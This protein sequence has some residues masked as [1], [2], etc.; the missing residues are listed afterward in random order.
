MLYFVVSISQVYP[1]GIASFLWAKVDPVYP[2]FL[3]LES[4]IIMGSYCVPGLSTHILGHLLRIILVSFTW[5]LL[6]PSIRSAPLFLFSG[7]T[8]FIKAL[9][10]LDNISDVHLAGQKYMELSI[11]FMT[12]TACLKKAL[13]I[14]LGI[15]LIIITLTT[16]FL[17]LGF[18]YFDHAITSALIPWFLGLETFGF[19]QFLLSS[20]GSI[21]EVCERHIRRWKFQTKLSQHRRKLVQACQPMRMR[22]GQVGIVDHEIRVNY[23]E[24]CLNQII[25]VLLA[26]NEGLS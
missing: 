5:M 18:S 4:D 19:V 15:A 3:L 6:S 24:E 23:T 21:S 7:I 9:R 12:V 16:C 17:I 14:Y 25:N 2:M 20:C 8:S 13:F 11:C 10:H 26:I 22:V 1:L